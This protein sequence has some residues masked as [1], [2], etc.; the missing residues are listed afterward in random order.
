MTP[1]IEAVPNFSEGRRQPVIDA[2]ATAARD[3]GAHI[4]DVSSDPDHNR[5]VITLAGEPETVSGSLFRAIAAAAQHIDL[6]QHQGVHPRL[7][8]ADVVP[9]IPLR[10][11]TMD[12]CVSLARQLGERIGNELH[13]PVFLYEAAATHPARANLADIRRGGY[14]K[15][16]GRIASDPLMQPDYGPPTLGPAGAVVIGARGPLIAYN[17]YLSTDDVQIA[18]DIA[19]NIRESGGGLPALKAIGLLV[20]ERAQVSMNVVNY[21]QTDLHTITEAVRAQAA[22]YGVT[23]TETELVGLVPQAA[24]IDA[25]LAYLGLPHATRHQTLETK[26][27]AATGTYQEIT[28]K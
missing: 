19:R 16:A 5:T 20:D 14:E 9:F 17:A 26:L 2:I 28:F 22:T 24:L 1:V 15:L 10:D 13:L 18:R 8:A 25:A 11:A 27:G 23:V 6:T 21:R 7:G 4:L 12:L 3:G